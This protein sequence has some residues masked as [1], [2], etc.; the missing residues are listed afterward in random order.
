[1]KTKLRNLVDAT[2]DTGHYCGQGLSGSKLHQE[3]IGKRDALWRE[4]EGELETMQTLLLKIGWVLEQPCWRTYGALATLLND[5]NDLL[6][7]E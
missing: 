7:G 1:M 3:S 6:G 4:L 5:I 2:Y